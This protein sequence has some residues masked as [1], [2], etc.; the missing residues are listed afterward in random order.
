V[1]S[2]DADLVVAARAGDRAA[3]AE[4]AER[5]GER[6]RRFLATMTGDDAAAEDLRQ[7]TLRLALERRD[8]LEV[9]RQRWHSLLV[10]AKP[11]EQVRTRRGGTRGERRRLRCSSSAISALWSAYQSPTYCSF[12]GK[13]G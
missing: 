5:H 13:L 4:L 3:F 11:V 12:S 7:D 8:Q 9:V 1:A 10:S 2:T 6:L